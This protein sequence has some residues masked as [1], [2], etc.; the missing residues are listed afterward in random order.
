M[1]IGVDETGSLERFSSLM[2]EVASSDVV[3][4]LL[5]LACD[6]NGFSPQD[7]APALKAVPVPL[8]GGMFPAI[9]SGNQVLHRGTIVAGLAIKPDIHVVTE[10]SNPDVDLDKTMGHLGRKSS[11]GETMFVFVDGYSQRIC[12]LIESVHSVFGLRYNHIGGGAGSIN[13]TALDMTNTPCVFTNDGLLK[14][15]ALLA[16]VANKSGVGVNHGWH[17]VCG[18]YKVTES[19]GN[20]IISLDWRPAFSVYRQ[21]IEEHAGEVITRESFFDV[22]KRFPFGIARMGSEI[23]V[24]DPFTV[25]EESLIL[26]TQIP[27]ESFVDVLTGDP[28]SLVEAAR[29]SYRAARDSFGCAKIGAVLLIDC[30]SRALFLADDFSREIEAVN[31]E[32]CPLIGCLSLGEIANDKTSYMELLNK[33]CV[34][35]VLEDA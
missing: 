4:G 5:V 22:A 28:D 17:K 30:V 1:I 19:V 31:Q 18:P 32:D 24:R 14:D 34:V 3:N 7:V 10:L 8:F 15:S 13:P 25:Q 20:A 29:S 26:A 35:G 23:I 16:V 9:I 33:T 2:Q 11:G 6:D 21:I 12:S 27:Q